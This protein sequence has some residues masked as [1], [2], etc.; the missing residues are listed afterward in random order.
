MDLDSN[1]PV[2]LLTSH[3]AGSR[4][5]GSVTSEILLRRGHTPELVPTVVFGRHPGRGAPGGGAVPDA[6][7]SGAL[8]GLK[9][10]RH[11]RAAQAILT[12]YFASPGQV[13]A[14]ARFIE[15]ARAH[16]PHL[17]VL[18]DPICGD[19]TPDGTAGGLYV[20]AATARALRD[21]L[22][23]L[24]DLIT[25]NAFELAWLTGTPIA[26]PEDAAQA[27]RTLG[28]D[29]L[30]TSVPGSPGALG[31]LAVEAGSSGAAWLAETGR[32]DRV[33]Y[34]TGDLFAV[35]ALCV[36][37]D[38]APLKTL[39]RIATQRTRAAIQATV[40]AGAGDLVLAASEAGAQLLEPV[41]MTRLGA[42]SPAWVM[43][44]DGCP[45]GWVGVMIDLNGL[46]APRLSVYAGITDAL[47]APEHAHV[48]AVDM[49]IGFET[50]PSGSG[51][52]A[53][54][55]EARARLGQRRSSIF[56][57]PLRTALPA[58]SHEEASRLNRAAGGPGL[59]RQSFNL[60]AKMREI[61][62]VMSP[63]LEGCLHESH[64]E[65]VFATLAG[66][67]MAHA[68][69]TPAGRAERLDVLAGQGLDPALFEPH[70]FKHK[71]AAPDDV[72]DAAACALAAVRLAEGNAL[73]LPADPPRDDTGLRMAIFA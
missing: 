22:L 32:L 60:F 9:A 24:A 29:T 38:G 18:V 54:E 47:N 67:P 45:A 16:N 44:L 51:G 72:L 6:L 25:P 37:L 58:R 21:R 53:C 55:R 1:P 5:G 73:C 35:Q 40:K 4:V 28:R 14:S 20:E 59:S 49:P 23:P 11:D 39:A 10:E 71:I 43:G 69:R 27:A 12:G 3:V 8:D 7:F 50:A 65:L 42:R 34:G 15:E 61:D 56:A 19:G 52:R 70:A 64:P 48:I 31:V 26:S 57:A 17:F 63:A 33:P 2:I 13:E 41:R 62:A 68:K 46:E 30:V 66:R 36:R